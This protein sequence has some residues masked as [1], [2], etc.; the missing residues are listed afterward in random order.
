MVASLKH[1]ILLA[2]VQRTCEPPRCPQG[3]Q[4]RAMASS[5]LAVNAGEHLSDYPPAKFH[6]YGLGT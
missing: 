4:L 5:Y 2:G 1:S 3:C 6:L